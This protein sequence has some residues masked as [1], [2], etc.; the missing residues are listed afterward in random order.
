MEI[1]KK[2]QLF[3]GTFSKLLKAYAVGPVSVQRIAAIPGVLQLGFCI[4]ELIK[5]RQRMFSHPTT[6]KQSSVVRFLSCL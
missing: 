2:P 4:Y 1:D 6:G 3:Q 5:R